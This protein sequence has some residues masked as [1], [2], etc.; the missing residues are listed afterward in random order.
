M[1]LSTWRDSGQHFTYKNY[2]IFYQETT[3]EKEVLL[4]LHGFPTSSW[5]WNK[6]WQ[7]LSQKFHLIAPDYIGF[8]FSA[9]PKKYNYT[10]GDQ[11]SLVEQLLSLKGIDKVHVLA[12]DFGDTVLQELLARYIERLHGKEYGLEIKSITLLNGGIIAGVHRPLPIQKALM[13]P[14][15]LFITPFLNKS[16]LR[17][18]FQNIFGSKT[19]PTEQEIDEFYSLMEYNRGKYVFHKLIRYMAER[20]EYRDRW[21]GALQHCPVPLELI[22]GNEDPISGAH[23]S[24]AVRKLIPNCEV[25]D[26]TEIGHYP[27]T[28]APD[29][30]LEHFFNFHQ[31]HFPS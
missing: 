13:S 29:L 12:H 25:V 17:K 14:I 28:E 22:D 20:V 2:P 31:R 18:S 9:K 26:L 3:S 15:G 7:P 19:Q 27:Q 23:L 4:L 30:V 21:V 1:K 24:E 6:I 11:A 10:I 16:K 5:D 8:G